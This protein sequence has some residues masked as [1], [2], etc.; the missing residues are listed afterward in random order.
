MFVG[1]RKGKWAIAPK[2]KLD[3]V[4]AKIPKEYA[5][6]LALFLMDKEIKTREDLKNALRSWLDYQVAK[7]E[8]IYGKGSSIVDIMK[9]RLAE[10]VV[11]I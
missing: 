5:T 6:S 7:A 2:E 4:I 3:E 8:A 1:F 11:V 10:E 9:K